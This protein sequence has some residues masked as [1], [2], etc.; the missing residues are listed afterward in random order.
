VLRGI[1]ILDSILALD[2]GTSAVKAA[3]LADDSGSLHL[4]GVGVVQQQVGNM[5]NGSIIDLARVVENAQLA[6]REAENMAR[7]TARKLVIGI[8][9]ELVKGMTLSLTYPKREHADR[10]IDSNEIKTM[11]HELQWQA[12][13]KIRH[14]IADDLSLSVVDLRLIN[15]SVVGIRLDGEPVVDLRGMTGK[16]VEFDI[17]NSFAPTFHFGNLQ[18]ISAELPMYDL[19]GIFVHSY[20]LAHSLALLREGVDALIIDMGAGTTDL[21]V[22]LDGKLQGTKS[23]ALGG[24]TFSKRIAFELG[25]SLEEAE[26]VKLKYCD[27]ALE[28]KSAKV[29]RDV[30]ESDLETWLMGLQ[31]SLHELDIEWLPSTVYVC[32]R[33]AGIPEIRPMLTQSTWYENFPHDDRPRVHPLTL[34]D[35][36][37]SVL[38][39]ETDVIDFL[40]AFALSHT[41]YHLLNQNTFVEG[42]LSNVIAG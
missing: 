19:K 21:A 5:Q 25:I 29:I 17:Y 10:R 40:P 37:T 3:V 42:V 28:R 33:S 22:V 9:G 1:M 20:A 32:G 41:A 31:F 18:A 12:Y 36:S 2:V 16:V 39:G 24:H 23:F 4:K 14:H 8:S 30:L 15:A 7:I 38:G 34:A 13:E 26:M 35:F 6:I 11:I 27:G